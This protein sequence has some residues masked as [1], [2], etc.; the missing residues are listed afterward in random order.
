MKLRDFFNQLTQNSIG[1]PVAMV[2]GVV[3]WTIVFTVLITGLGLVG[4]RAVLTQQPGPRIPL[5]ETEAPLPSLEPGTT[6]VLI[7]TVE[8]TV[9]LEPVPLP[10]LVAPPPIATP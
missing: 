9:T 3:S 8:L 1:L 10:T 4:E 6:P 5:G 7:G 2:M